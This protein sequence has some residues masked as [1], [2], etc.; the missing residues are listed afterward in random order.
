VDARRAK[1]DHRRGRFAELRWVARTGST[2]ADLLDA[3]RRGAGECALVADVQDAGR[4]RLDR[5]WTAPSGAS[6]LMSVLV[7]PPFPAAGAHLVGTALG[8]AA[9]ETVQEL[10]GVEVGLKWPN[11][12]VAQLPGADGPERKLGGLLAEL[13]AGPSG[14]A[15]VAG[16][17]LNVAWPDGFPPELA[18]TAVSLDQLGA[19]VD[20]EPL[21]QGILARLE[22]LLARVDPAGCAELLATYRRWCRTLGRTVRVELP[23]GE[24]VGD[25]VDLGHDGALVV[26]TGDGVRHRVDVGDV[27]HLRSA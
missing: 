26:R 14:D 6:L 12:V 9:V 23:R 2:N 10:G 18:G 16:I 19:T 22:A 7:R 20:R 13:S 27:V 11:D 5:S 4:G 1:A 21:A 3:A 24:L 17:G 25:A 15:V 8:I